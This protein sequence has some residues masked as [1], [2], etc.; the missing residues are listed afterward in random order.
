MVKHG[1]EKNPVGAHH[2]VGDWLVQRFSAVVMALYTIFAV[3]Y[4]VWRSPAS[5]EQWKAL[6]TGGFFRLA[7]QLA[8]V[9]LLWHAWIG[10]RDILIDY[11]HGFALRLG[12]QVVVA[13]VLVFY[14][15]WSVSILWGR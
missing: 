14:L 7:T 4:L 5:Y 2:G 12:A 13:V 15:I 9:A 1:Y 11:L 6:F 10:M 3:P 8:I